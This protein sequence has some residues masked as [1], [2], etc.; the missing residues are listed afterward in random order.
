MQRISSIPPAMSNW[1]GCNLSSYLYGSKKKKFPKP[2]ASP[3][4]RL[5]LSANIFSHWWKSKGVFT[6][7]FDRASKGNPGVAGAVGLIY[8]PDSKKIFSFCWGLGFC[9]NNQVE[10]YSLLMAFQISRQIGIKEIQIL[11]DSEVLIKLL[12]SNLQF[13]KPSLD[14]ILQRI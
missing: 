13:N 4:W 1:L 5:R 10:F 14:K 11:G 6:I 12:N 7:F 2:T 9:S 3:P 8:S